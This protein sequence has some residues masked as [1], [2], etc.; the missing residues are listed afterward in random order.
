MG[1]PSLKCFTPALIALTIG[2]GCSPLRDLDSAAS[3]NGKREQGAA[4]SAGALAQTTRGGAATNHGGGT[5]SGGTGTSVGAGGAVSGGTTVSAG[6][7]PPATGGSTAAT[8]GT[9]PSTGGT[10]PATG[11]AGGTTPTAGG[12]TPTAGG[13]TPATGAAGGSGP[14]VGGSSTGA[15]GSGSGGTATTAS[16]GNPAKG[17]A[18]GAGGTATGGT[19]SIAPALPDMTNSPVTGAITYSTGASWDVDGTQWP[20]FEIHTPT[21]SYWLVK[22]AAAI[23]SIDDPGGLQ[24]IGYA[25]AFRPLRGVPNLGGCCQ[26]G[27]PSKLGLPVMTTEIDAQSVTT[28]T[29]LRLVSKP[30]TGGAYWLVWDFYLTHVT[31]TVNRAQA[32]FG[33]S[34]RGT[35]GGN[36]DASDQLVLSTGVT[37]GAKTAFA[38]DL[39]GPTEWVYL[40]DPAAR[41]SLFLLQH[42]DNDLPE[43]YLVADGDSA[44]FTFGSGK[45]TST[46]LRFSLGLID[47]TDHSAV[48]E[49]V[50]FITNFIGQ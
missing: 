25:Y 17:G 39:P 11:A 23:V 30:V 9:P 15:G 41:S 3:G 38:G 8:G 44:M 40:A 26:S 22:S 47:R 2:I 1:K 48:S 5:E 42:A 50:A 45:L 16:A 31:V 27:D 10:A 49:R 34:Y 28:T 7:A 13:T 12:T 36:L 32:P 19:N 29:H 14:S 33:F 20:A 18:S 43:T 21:A 46:P 4:G 6:G 24:W 37:Q 35:P